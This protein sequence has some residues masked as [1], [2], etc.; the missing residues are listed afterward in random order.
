ME[1]DSRTLEAKLHRTNQQFFRHLIRTAKFLAQG[2]FRAGS[3]DQ[4]ATVNRRVRGDI[5][6]FGQFRFRVEGEH[7]HASGCSKGDISAALDRV[8]IGQASR[9]DPQGQ[10]LFNLTTAGDIEI[11]AFGGK[12]GQ[13]LRGWVRLYSIMDM[14]W[15]QCGSQQTIAFRHRIQVHN[16]GWAVK[17]RIGNKIRQTPGQCRWSWR[18]SIHQMQTMGMRIVDRNSRGCSDR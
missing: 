12:T 6:Q 15:I 18:T 2:P 17:T 14:G 1:A 8:A 4:N 13:Q 11:G 9:R 7:G 16:Q 10:A 3:I 5:G